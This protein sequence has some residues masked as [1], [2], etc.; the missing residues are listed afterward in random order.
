MKLH[1]INAIILHYWYHSKRSLPRIMDILFW[2]TMNLA[3][4]GFISLFLQKMNTAGAAASSMLLGAIILWMVFQR[5]QQDVSIA[6][7]EDIWARNIINLFVTPLKASE[8]LLGGMAV[9][10]LKTV[11]IASYMSGLAILLYHFNIFSLGLPLLPFII[12]LLMF[13][14]AVGIFISAL[15]FRF[16]TDS[17]ILAFSLAFVIQPIS[18]VFYPLSVLPLA[19]QKIAWFLPTTHIFEG[20]REV[21]A[22][23]GFSFEHLVWAFGLNFVFILLAS[24][25]YAYMFKRVKELGLIS[26][27]E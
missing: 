8:Y 7:L 3:L 25:Y 11:F 5:A 14:W 1:R 12:S 4:W 10:F 19:V 16:G 20:M 21:L 15:M 26:K 23:H 13:G 6:F 18:A 2:P 24:L 22:D 17:Q 27:I 9:A